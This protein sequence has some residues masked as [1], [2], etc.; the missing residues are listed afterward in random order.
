MYSSVYG[1]RISTEEHAFSLSL[2]LKT[3][4][5]RVAIKLRKFKSSASHTGGR[6]TKRE[7]R[8]AAIR[9]KLADVREGEPSLMTANKCIL[10]SYSCALEILLHGG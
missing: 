1:R 2:K 6:Q 5:S 9:V 10:L 3:W 7:L 8:E 4:L